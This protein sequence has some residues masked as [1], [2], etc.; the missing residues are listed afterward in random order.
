MLN[1]LAVKLSTLAGNVAPEGSVGESPIAD[2]DLDELADRLWHARGSAIV[3]SDSQDVPVQVLVNFI[4]HLLGS[5]GNTVDIERPSRQ[6]Q[7]L[8]F[9]NSSRN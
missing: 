9:L 5:Y 8:K 1:R 6:R 7:G 4:N 3:L 2:D